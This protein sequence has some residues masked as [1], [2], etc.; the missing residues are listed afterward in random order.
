ME[1]GQVLVAGQRAS[2][3]A[4]PVLSGDE[5]TVRPHGPRWVGRGARKLDHALR[6]WGPE[7]LSA[8]GRRCIDVGASTGGFTQALLLAGAEHV[9]A[10]DVGQG[11]LVREIAEDSRVTERSGTNV[12][13]LLPADLGGPADLVVA[14]L[15][16]ISLTTVMAD[17]VGLLRPSGD[18]VVLVKPQFEVGRGRLSSRGLVTDPTDRRAALVAVVEAA[19]E[20]GWH[21]HGLLASPVPG[22]TGNVEYLL[23]ARSGASATMDAARVRELA[24]ELATAGPT[25]GG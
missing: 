12:R 11:Q 24:H 9:V 5:I 14:D 22:T 20:H 8:A 1:E 16:F 19:A 6:R 17:L 10:L 2:K 13:G 4:Q 18:L 3:P 15:S 25:R 7:G 23:W 21:P